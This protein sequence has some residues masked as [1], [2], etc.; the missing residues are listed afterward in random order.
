MKK[1]LI[2]WVGETDH[3][4]AE[5]Q[6]ARG[7]GPIAAALQSEHFDAV[8]LLTNYPHERSSQYCA[9]LRTLTAHPHIELTDIALTSP[10]DHAAIYREVTAQLAHVQE[11]HG[12][13][14]RTFHLSPGTPAMATIWVLLAKSR[15]PARLIQ[16]HIDGRVL[17]ANVDFDLASDFLPEYLQR[18][19][20]RVNRVV[21]LPY[22]VPK[23]FAGIIH[24]SKVMQTQIARAQ[25]IA[26]H[27]LP[28]LILG[29]TGTGKELFAE[30]IHE[31]SG[32]KGNFIPVNCGAVSSELINSEL[33][34]HKAGAFTGANKDRKG[35]FR[36][37]EGGTLFLDEIGDLPL[38]AQVGL[39]RALQQKQIVPLGQSTPLPIDVR[40]IA[41]THRDL[42][43]HVIDGTFREDLFHRLAVGILQLPPLREREGD[44]QLL[45]AY[46]MD[47]I[48]RDSAMAPEWQEKFLSPS[49][50]KF[51]Q[52]Y[53]W[54]GNI[55]ELY[56]TLTRAAVW[57]RQAELLVE[58]IKDNLL[59]LG[60]TRPDPSLTPLA[61]GID[62]DAF[63]LNIEHHYLQEAMETS[64]GKKK[65]AA[66]LL[67]IKNYQ[68]LAHRLKKHGFTVEE[69]D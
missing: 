4:A 28:V 53:R 5:G 60:S 58:D 13:V 14:H 37:A 52:C 49:A 57:G 15:F 42:H 47:L 11:Q 38:D 21:D 3:R 20:A 2:S 8:H 55:R 48:N 33:F 16:T 56:H 9:W 30:A 34:G 29:E 26:V 66:A 24:E 44:V 22:S 39:L 68:T 36:E 23:E 43:A 69:T 64:G 25:R 46:L 41:A 19:D 35:H 32:R 65:K 45:A 27:N 12:P 50:K 1:W 7:V 51:L 18:S 54:P 10:I 6:L 59:G 17:D 63:L 31:A 40:I 62:L 67:G 61:Q